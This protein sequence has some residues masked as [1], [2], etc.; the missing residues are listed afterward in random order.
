MK[1]T[2]E[3]NNIIMEEAS[4]FDIEQIL[5]CGQCFH[6]EKLKDKDYVVVARRHLLHIEQTEDKVI[7]YDTDK[8]TFDTVWKPYFDLDCDYA[9]IKKWLVQNEHSILKK[10]GV[11]KEAVT[12]YSGIRILNQDFFETLIS[13]IISQNKQIPHIKQIV[14]T[15]SVKY[16]DPAGEVCGNTYHHFP[17]LEQ[18]CKVSENELRLCKTG[19]RAPYIVAACEKLVQDAELEERL[20]KASSKEV[21]DELMQIKGVGSKV[22]S[23]VALFSLSKCDAFP[24]DVWIQRI[25]EKIYFDREAQKSEIISLALELY[26]SY[27]GYAQQYLFYYARENR[28]KI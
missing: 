5:E 15:L 27:G 7:F 4:S 6:Y 13:F 25:M 18:L 17:T 28:V 16:G 26:G 11:L 21:L 20:K 8:K 14:N 9:K 12:A 3:D 24:V 10:D 19:F 2:V 1:I 23:C 22:A